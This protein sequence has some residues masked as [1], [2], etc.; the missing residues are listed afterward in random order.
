MPPHLTL[1]LGDKNAEDAFGAPWEPRPRLPVCPI[2]IRSG[3]GAET[4]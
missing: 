2:L 1:R 4:R 3:D